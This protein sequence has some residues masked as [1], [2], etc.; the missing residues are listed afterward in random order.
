MK[1][2]VTGSLGRIS[3]PLTELLVSKGHEVTVIS[4]NPEKVTDITSLGANASIG[5]LQDQEFLTSAFQDA[6]AVYAMVPP[7]NY[8][9]PNL[10]LMNY[11][12]GIAKNYKM[13]IAKSAVKRVVYLSS[14]GADLKK[15]SGIILPYHFAE[16]IIGGLSAA[17][18]LTVIRP[19]T[20]YYNLLSFIRTIKNTGKISSN[21][22]GDDLIS[23]V[24]PLDIATAVAEELAKVNPFGRDLRY[25]ASDELTCSETATILGS[26]IG[27]P[28]LQWEFTPS[29]EIQQNLEAAGMQ[30]KIASDYLSMN[31]SMH[32]GTFFA[33]YRKNRPKH[34]GRIKMSNFAIDFSKSYEQS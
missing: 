32:N 16:E 5:R 8:F 11:V 4:S 22:G 27:K 2:I 3:K 17:V 20:M 34:L 28:D 9:D 26:A 15:N 6:D 1:I 14:I 10:D 12:T 13:A 33:H 7:A 25:V 24:S 30:P 23:W 29:D 31:D 19:T 21:Y 18:S